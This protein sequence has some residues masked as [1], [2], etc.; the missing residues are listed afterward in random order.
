MK[1][2]NIHFV[3]AS[4]AKKPTQQEVAAAIEKANKNLSTIKARIFEP[5]I[6]TR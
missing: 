6:Y 1:P 2:T 4:I 3:R 5:Q